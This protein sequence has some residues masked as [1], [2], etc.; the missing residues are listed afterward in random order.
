VVGK[1]LI[2]SPF[3]AA[4]TCVCDTSCQSG[5]FGALLR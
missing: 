3:F 4:A 5:S 2:G 1:M